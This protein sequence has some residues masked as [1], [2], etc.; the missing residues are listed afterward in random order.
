MQSISS[1]RSPACF[2]A[3]SIIPRAFTDFPPVSNAELSTLTEPPGPDAP[4]ATLRRSE[5]NSTAKI[6]IRNLSLGFADQRDA[7][8]TIERSRRLHCF[9][10]I[11][12]RPAAGRFRTEPSIDPLHHRYTLGRIHRVFQTSR[13]DLGRGIQPIKVDV[14]QSQTPALVLMDECKRRRCHALGDTQPAGV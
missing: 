7:N 1:R 8:V 14:T 4:A 6:F 11:S 12:G 2:K 5:E 10:C 13:G 3:T 9:R